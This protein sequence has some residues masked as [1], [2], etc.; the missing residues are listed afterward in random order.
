MRINICICVY[1]KEEEG[2][3]REGGRREGGGGKYVYMGRKRGEIG[4]REVGGKKEE[5]RR[6]R[7]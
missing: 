5:G 1:G 3:R 7:R 4:G 6:R 2:D